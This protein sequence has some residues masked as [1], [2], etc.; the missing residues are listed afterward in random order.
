MIKNQ[1]LP[2]LSTAWYHKKSEATF[3]DI[4]ACVR[5]SIWV[6]KYIN[7]S[8]IDGEYVKM[9]SE[10]WETLLDQLSRAA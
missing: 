2:I 6:K 5:R 10:Q 8:R 7:D 9:K 4:I 3:S 1:S